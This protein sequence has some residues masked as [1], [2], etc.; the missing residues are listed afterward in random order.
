MCLEELK[1]T[2]TNL[3]QE[4]S[5]PGQ[6]L[7]QAPPKYKCGVLPLPDLLGNNMVKMKELCSQ[8]SSAPDVVVKN[9]KRLVSSKG[10]ST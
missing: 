10:S 1:K 5:C 3:S 8:I 4:R 9:Q 7:N 2:T 6:D